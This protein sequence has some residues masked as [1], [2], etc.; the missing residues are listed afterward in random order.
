MLICLVL[1]VISASD[2]KR[3]GNNSVLLRT[4]GFWM[5]SDVKEMQKVEKEQK[6]PHSFAIWGEKEKVTVHNENLGR[7]TEVSV[8]EVCGDVDLVVGGAGQLGEDDIN[9]CLVDENTAFMLFGDKVIEGKEIYCQ[10]RKLIVR[11]VRK[12]LKDTIIIRPDGESKEILNTITLQK[13]NDS[14]VMNREQDFKNRHSIDGV[15]LKTG[16][17]DGL[18][19]FIS[20]LLPY[21]MVAEIVFTYGKFLYFK[22]DRPMILIAGIL[23]ICIFIKLF[24]HMF[25]LSFQFPKDILPTK[26]SDFSFWQTLAETKQEEIQLLLSSKKGTSVM[27]KITSLLATMKYSGLA[28]FLYFAFFRTVKPTSEKQVAVGAIVSWVVVFGMIVIMKQ[29]GGALLSSKG[30]WFLVP[31]YMA[32]VY[33]RNLCLTYL[34]VKGTL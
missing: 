26:W 8:M 17:I 20:L 15:N 24:L 22:R 13:S 27:Q 29:D 34:G 18:A 30:V 21:C 10:N 16:Y 12:D 25:S 5:A 9:G 1:A 2:V 28:L 11:G 6:S 31:Y 14:G 7:S 19:Q 33:I 4:E 23:V 32:A 3:A